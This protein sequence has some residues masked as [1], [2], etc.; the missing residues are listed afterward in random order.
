MFL[1][2]LPKLLTCLLIEVLGTEGQVWATPEACWDEDMACFVLFLW[3]LSLP[4]LSRTPDSSIPLPVGTCFH[5]SMWKTSHRPCPGC[6]EPQ[7]WIPHAFLTL[8]S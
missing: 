3:G 8:M 7:S 1:P 5:V 2:F 6:D 4:L